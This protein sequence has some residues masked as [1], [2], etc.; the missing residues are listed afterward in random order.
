M[1]TMQRVLGVLTMVT[2]GCLAPAEAEVAS[3]EA[4]AVGAATKGSVIVHNV[5][6]YG[7]SGADFVDDTAA[8]QLAFEAAQSQRVHF[9][10]GTYYVSAS[11][12]LTNRQGGFEISG[13]GIATRIVAVASSEQR[14]SDFPHYPLFD[15]TGSRYGTIR[16][17][18]V[19]TF[20]EWP[21]T[22]A[23]KF[24]MAEPSCAFLMARACESCGQ[25]DAGSAGSHRFRDVYVWGRYSVANV[26]NIASEANVFDGVS[27]RDA[28]DDTA[29]VGFLFISRPDAYQRGAVELASRYRSIPASS[30]SNTVV[31]LTN[32]T[33][34]MHSTHSQTRVAF[35]EDAENVD[36]VSLTAA[37]VG[38][39]EQME[40]VAPIS[41]VNVFGARFERHGVNIP[42]GFAFR[43][44][45]EARDVTIIGSTIY[46]LYGADETAVV[47]LQ[48]SGGSPSP[49]GPALIGLDVG[50][51][52]SS[53]IDSGFVSR[54]RLEASGNTFR[55][56]STFDNL[57]LPED[58][59]G[60]MK[61]L[62]D[63]TR[64]LLGGRTDAVLSVEGPD[65]VTAKAAVDT[66]IVDAGEGDVQVKLDAFAPE[67]A[68]KTI[69][70]IDDS[71]ATVLVVGHG[72]QTIDGEANYE[73]AAAYDF[74]TVVRV[75]GDWLVV[76]R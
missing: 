53:S 22:A 62:A 57:D 39:T 32:S 45:G 54:A 73:L 55:R 60:N 17:L 11:L 8:I 10:A 24:D 14:F 36:I 64:T 29:R 20:N 35:I 61:Q 13:D 49:F 52:R 46:Q 21:S 6:D 38:A 16:D 59:H 31:R 2:V 51:L 1:M 72:A 4:A 70:R 43:G 47:N 33:I 67:G 3:A 65:F 30:Q 76:G 5:E 50:V 7:A 25:G 12:D 44:V 34:G 58:E 9:P 66:V 18:K 41:R 15:L 48:L 74:V 75:Q 71:D 69:K 68:R 37:T 56:L 42:R 28:E 27:I 19:E 40:L 26:C 23:D 63:G